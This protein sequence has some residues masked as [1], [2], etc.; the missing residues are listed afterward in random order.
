MKKN[1][2]SIIIAII[3]FVVF[4]ALI[5][6]FSF[7][8]DKVKKVPDGTVGNT[9]GNANNHGL[10]CEYNGVVYFSNPYDNG[11]LY[12]MSPDESKMKKLLSANVANINAGGDYLFY[13]QKEANGAAGLGYV[14]S[15]NGLYRAS[16]KGR[17]TTCLAQEIIFNAQL[18]GNNI[19][20]QTSDSKGA[21]FYKISID[22][23][24]KVLLTST[25]TNFACAMTDGTVFYNGYESNHYLYRYN[26]KS[27]SSYVV[28]EGNVWNPI[29]ESGYV[30]YMDVS[31]DYRL[32]R[33]S[34][35]DDYVEIL[36][37]DTVDC[38]N[39]AGGYIYYQ[40]NSSTAP[41]LKRMTLDGQNV[42][43]IAEGNYTNIN[44]TSRYVYF[45]PFGSDVPMYRTPVSGPVNVNTF[46][47][48]K[49]AAIKANK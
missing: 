27:D 45:T 46:D 42:E 32:C 37:H 2:K 17:D 36:T 38:Y 44:A 40:K 16:L 19:Y 15:I 47:A 1:D 6:V 28:W 8:T 39:I 13:Y 41:A 11:N 26:T 49:E 29:Y 31:S 48:A 20:Y 7:F 33:Y 3:A 21:A 12:S 22:E 9:P 14:R 34:L 4:I 35:V 24:E 5:V 30:Y 18:I 10:F 23:K 43:I 25:T